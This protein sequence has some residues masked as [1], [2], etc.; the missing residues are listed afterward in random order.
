[1]KPHGNENCSGPGYSTKVYEE[2]PWQTDRGATRNAAALAKQEDKGA[3]RSKAR[4]Q[5][6]HTAKK[7]RL[8]TI[9]AGGPLDSVR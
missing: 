5:I 2:N 6:Q 7:G 9:T 8:R 1:M 4:D 3:G